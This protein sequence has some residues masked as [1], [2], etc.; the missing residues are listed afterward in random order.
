MPWQK[1]RLEFVVRV[2]LERN[3]SIP[4][5]C[6]ETPDFPGVA[7]YA[8]NSLVISK[9][10]LQKN[11]KYPHWRCLTYLAKFLPGLLWSL[12]GEQRHKI[13]SCQK[14]KAREKNKNKKQHHCNQVFG[15]TV[16]QNGSFQ[17]FCSL[18]NMANYTDIPKKHLIVTVVVLAFPP[19]PP[20]E[21]WYELKAKPVSFK[22]N[23]WSFYFQT[24]KIGT[25]IFVD[26]CVHT[27][28]CREAANVCCWLYFQGN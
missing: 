17:Q 7:L 3:R 2:R 10:V 12:K 6:R 8:D 13:M 5:C 11:K 26:P 20:P 28:M 21:S 19:P 23:I 1:R 18:L 15:I 4:P 22:K 14:V 25:F 24:L 9:N 16:F 27:E